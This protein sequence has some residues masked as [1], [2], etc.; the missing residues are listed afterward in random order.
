MP[1]H[2]HRAVCPCAGKPSAGFTLIEL[3]VTMAIIAILTAVALPAYQNYI[4]RSNIKSAG[5]DL[6]ALALVVENAHQL[7]FSY[8][9]S[10]N[11]ITSATS[12]FGAFGPTVGNLFTYSLTNNGSAT[13]AYQLAATGNNSTMVANCKLTLDSNGSRTFASGSGTRACGYQTSW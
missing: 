6:V 1:A 5:A 10:T 11:G 8:A 13:P 3:I 7:T 12:G 2:H 9:S 4:I